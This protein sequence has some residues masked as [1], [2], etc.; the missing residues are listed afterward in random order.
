MCRWEPLPNLHDLASKFALS[1]IAYYF[2]SSHQ[3]VDK[4]VAFFKVMNVVLILIIGEL[5]FFEGQG[6]IYVRYES[7]SDAGES[8]FLCWL[9][10]GELSQP[11][12][13]FFSESL[14]MHIAIHWRHLGVVGKEEM[15]QEYWWSIQR[16]WRGPSSLSCVIHH[17][18]QN[19]LR[20]NMCGVYHVKCTIFGSIAM[21]RTMYV[22]VHFNVFK[23]GKVLNTLIDCLADTSCKREVELNIN[24]YCTVA[25]YL[26]SPNCHTYFFM[27]RGTD[28]VRVLGICFD[29]VFL[30]WC[31]IIFTKEVQTSVFMCPMSSYALE[32]FLARLAYR[33]SRVMSALNCITLM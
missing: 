22:V 17:Q 32:I 5:I 19:W 6:H 29:K 7:Q 12:Q 27:M 11:Q 31:W 2:L 20:V 8:S 26:T 10:F 4:A 24:N 9:D 14:F 15:R 3:D 25:S 16:S 13:I 33:A 18:M 28:A 30:S 21:L 23:G 1:K